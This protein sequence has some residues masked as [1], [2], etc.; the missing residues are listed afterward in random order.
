VSTTTQARTEPVW[1]GADVTM[2]D[3]LSALADIRDTFDHGEAG[4]QEHAH[5][6]NCVMTLV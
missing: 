1:H 6:R 3:V 5:P 2:R 4:D